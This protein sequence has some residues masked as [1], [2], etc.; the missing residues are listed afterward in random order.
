MKAIV[1]IDNSSLTKT[2]ASVKIAYDAA[3][4]DQ[5]TNDYS[6]YTNDMYYGCSS[7]LAGVTKNEVKK[8]KPTKKAAGDGD[9]DDSAF[10]LTG[11]AAS[12]AVLAALA[13]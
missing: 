6:K 1:D 12:T 10:A 11:V 8:G 13:F 5:A 2:G 3:N 9:G 4:A 7:V